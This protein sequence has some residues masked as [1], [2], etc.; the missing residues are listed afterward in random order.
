MSTTKRINQKKVDQI[1]YQRGRWAIYLFL[2]IVVVCQLLPFY[3]A[4]NASMKPQTDMSSTLMH[5]QHEIAWDN[6]TAAI[7]DGQIL[8]SVVNSVI[9]TVC[10]TLI[11]CVVGAAAAYPL[12]RRATRFNK[13]I[14]ALI[15][16]TMMVPPLSILVPLYTMLVN[17]GGAN[18]YW[19]IV[20]VLAAI[21]MPLSVFLY[22]AFIRSIPVSVDEAG[23]I[24]GANRFT[25]FV[26]LILPMLKPVTATVIIMTGTT[27][28]N[29][30][31]LSV[32]LLAAAAEP[33]A[34][35]ATLGGLPAHRRR[36]ADNR[37]ARRLLLRCEQQQ[38]RYRC[39]CRTDR[40]RSDG[41][42]LPVPA[43][44]LHRRHDRRCGEV[45]F[46]IKPV[47]RS[48]VVSFRIGSRGTDQNRSVRRPCR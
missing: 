28:W 23:M 20:L 2:A 25:I 22:T 21:N 3:L 27:V 42:R 15:L 47:G 8:H 13:V 14:S 26:R 45:T 35:G 16:A 34:P 29:D 9:V 30:Y 32:Y 41:H 12:A 40:R 4:I 48:H 11:V 43:E 18:T 39:G 6:W 31:A 38:P 1:G 17:L 44:V 19:G 46:G 37:T 5:R 10:T 24:D 7:T 33:R 36:Q